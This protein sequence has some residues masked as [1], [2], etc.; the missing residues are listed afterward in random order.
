[1]APSPCRC[2]HQLVLIAFL[3]AT[4]CHAVQQLDDPPTSVAP[5]ED[6]TDETA[7]A[8][9]SPEHSEEIDTMTAQDEISALAKDV[10]VALPAVKERSPY[11]QPA[12][13][14]TWNHRAKIIMDRYKALHQVLQ[15]RFTKLDKDVFEPQ[16]KA[17]SEAYAKVSGMA[18]REHSLKFDGVPNGE[19][20]QIKCSLERTCKSCSYNLKERVCLTSKIAMGYSPDAVF[21]A[22]S[23]S[24][25][26][27]GGQTQYH[28]YPGMFEQLAMLKA[29]ANTTAEECELECSQDLNCM[30]YAFLEKTGLCAPSTAKLDY[31]PD[32][33]YF[34]K[35]KRSH[36][37]GDPV[38]IETQKKMDAVDADFK[39]FW[40]DFAHHSK[41]ERKVAYMESH[42]RQISHKA[43]Q[44]EKALRAELEAIHKAQTEA[45]AIKRRGAQARDMLRLASQQEVDAV[46]GSKQAEMNLAG[47]E[48]K[49]K[50]FMQRIAKEAQTRAADGSKEA[51]GSS[52]KKRRE[53]EQQQENDIRSDIDAKREA[54]A[55]A[56]SKL[57]SAR[58]GKADA[59]SI[60]KK[61]DQDEVK[62]RVALKKHRE[63]YKSEAEKLR[64]LAHDASQV[65]RLADKEQD[66]DLPPKF[67]PSEPSQYLTSW[68]TKVEKHVAFKKGVKLKMLEAR[69]KA[70]QAEDRDAEIN[71]EAEATTDSTLQDS[72]K[73]GGAS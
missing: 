27:K 71:E 64:L 4:C 7:H 49:L 21:Y 59:E 46:A 23:S 17:P 13:L 38:D 14:P 2:H 19:A 43:A 24:D 26:S 45:S 12:A 55:N 37:F 65:K 20:C 60:V 40:Y 29:K 5:G 73:G 53:V 66:F 63:A 34:E 44:S 61:N 30:G 22:K 67:T 31:N 56:E 41:E 72:T 33:E 6:A 57:D 36:T 28:M 39:K 54:K 1:M 15:A 51:K 35:P 52:L 69:F 68:D 9:A 3:V 11:D 62:V 32:F 50:D 16:P 25:L 8:A 47:S 42:A 10:K 70:Q 18:V 48:N 58:F